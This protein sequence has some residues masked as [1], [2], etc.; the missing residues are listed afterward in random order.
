MK[1]AVSIPDEVFA[2]GE[3]LAKRLG[4]TRSHLYAEAIRKFVETQRSTGVTA[5]LNQVYAETGSTIDS[6]LAEIQLI[7]V[8]GDGW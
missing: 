6:V 8:E 2:R 3:A 1:T 4:V 7:S 5:A